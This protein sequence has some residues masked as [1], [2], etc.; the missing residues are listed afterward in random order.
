MEKPSYSDY[1]DDMARDAIPDMDAACAALTDYTGND[2]M[3]TLTPLAG[4]NPA[5]IRAF[6]NLADCFTGTDIVSDYSGM[7]ITR[8]KSREDLEKAAMGEWRSKRYY[9]DLALW[10]E[11]HPD[12]E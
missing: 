2:T 6:A 10:R 1:T 9:E 11:T 12:A 3:A 8:R 4:L 5:T 7:R